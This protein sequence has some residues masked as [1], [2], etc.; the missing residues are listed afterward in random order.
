MATAL[1]RLSFVARVATQ[2]APCSRSIQRRIPGPQSRFLSTTTHFRAQNGSDNNAKATLA[3]IPDDDEP[4]ELFGEDDVEDT[5]MFGDETARAMDGEEENADEDLEDEDEEGSGWSLDDASGPMDE[6]LER[7]D[8][9]METEMFDDIEGFVEEGESGEPKWPP[10]FFSMD[11]ERDDPGEDPEFENDDITSTAHGELEQH[12]ELR[13]FA[14]VMVWDMPL[15]F[16]T[17]SPQYCS[18]YNICH[19]FRTICISCYRANTS[20]MLLTLTT[21]H[22]RA[23]QAPSV[24]TP[25]RFR[26]TTYLGETHP[27]SRKVVMTFSLSALPN[28]TEVQSSKLIKLLGVRYNPESTTA[29]L[30]CELYPT[31][32]QN[33][34]YLGDLL[35][36]LMTEAKDAKDTFEDVPFDFRHHKP[37]KRYPFPEEW[38]LTEERRKQLDARRE[39]K[40]KLEEQRT[41]DGTVVQGAMLIEDMLRP[42]AKSEKEAVLQMATGINQK[43][44]A[45]KKRATRIS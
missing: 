20:G 35:D 26:Y 32:A 16:S 43:G 10:G 42:A 27:A 8:S 15:L 45:Q 1:K 39:E 13:E 9:D 29:K 34:R 40:S 33:K 14:R 31:A 24:E 3:N 12:R 22:A 38:K 30:S 28:F 23:F 44:K 25:I 41:L 2:R 5:G 4:E 19:P 7:I 36:K 6:E 18:S 11:E 17:F 21:D 37:K